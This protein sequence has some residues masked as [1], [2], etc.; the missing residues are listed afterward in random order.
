MWDPV[1]HEF[2]LFSLA[3][4][5]HDLFSMTVWEIVNFRKVLRLSHELHFGQDEK[6]SNEKCTDIP[7]GSSI[8][9]IH[10]T[11]FKF[12]TVETGS[13]NYMSRNILLHFFFF[14]SM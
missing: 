8:Y 10:I 12:L 4:V 14:Y 11:G 5:C 1:K 13:F 9:V 3:S 6:S 2:H 7:L